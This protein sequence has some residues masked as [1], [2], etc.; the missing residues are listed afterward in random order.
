MSKLLALASVALM[1][2]Y[3]MINRQIDPCST[4]GFRPLDLLEYVREVEYVLDASIAH[5]FMP[6]SF[7]MSENL[8]SF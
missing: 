3:V 6:A 4:L 7:L 1:Q 5:K 2:A 8:T